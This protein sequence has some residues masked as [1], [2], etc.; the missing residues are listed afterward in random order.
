[1]SAITG[2]YHTNNEPVSIDQGLKMMKALQ[3]YPSDDVQI[4]QQKNVFLGCHAQWITPESIGEQLPYY[5]Y[6]RQLAITADAM[7]DNREELFDKLGIHHEE[8]KGMPDSQLI[9]LAYSKWED[10]TVKHLIGDFAFMIWDEK[11]QKLFGARDF[12][13]A[14][15]LYFYHNHQRFAFCTVMEPLLR[16]PY[17]KKE[18]NEEWL[19]EYLAIP[20][21]IDA[22]DVSKTVIKDIQQ[23]PPSHTINVMNCKVE[24]SKYQVLKSD[25][26]I[27][28]KTDVEYIETFRDIFQNA[29]DVRLRT[30]KEVGSH[31]SGGL[32]SGS[33]VS[34]AAKT[35]QKHNKKLH[36]YSSIPV[37]DFNDYT[38]KNY[39]PDERS[40]IRATVDYVGNIEDHYLSLDNKNPYTDIDDWLDI[41]ET[42]YKF[43]ENSF[44]MKGISEQAN[45]NNIGILL[46]GARGNFTISWGS[47][48][49]YYGHLLKRMKW[50][51]LAREFKTYSRNI[52]MGRKSLLPLIGKAAFPIMNHE[53]EDSF[54]MLINPNFAKKTNAF[55]KL[56]SCKIGGDGFTELS[57]SN[58]RNYLIDN[59]FIWNSNGVAFSKLSLQYGLLMRDP[60]NDIRVINYC[61]SLPLEQFINNGMDRA[62]IRNATKGYLPD[63][64]RLNQ[65]KY[66]LQAADWLH[67]MIPCW[68]DFIQEVK[69][70]LQDKAAAQYINMESIRNAL[71]TAMEMP[72]GDS[73]FNPKLRMLMRGIIVYRFLQSFDLEGGDTY[74]KRME[75]AEIGV[76]GC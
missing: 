23:V 18:L 5:D 64:V 3:K 63:K 75:R 32:D 11:K 17:I 27:K 43:F 30:F 35:L 44:W 71:S 1:M 28:F 19:A 54:P 4:W 9:L 25:E 50:I 14:R 2:I 10:E 76:V 29:N 74:E 38:P 51:S 62:L 12:S 45:K 24:L 16:L 40:Y 47:A 8:R 59:E 67:R 57:I 6:E 66:G 22:V 53:D 69:E 13:G 31:L 34:F 42:P 41:I 72:S 21:F 36:T 73:A 58:Q 46:N 68:T 37:T 70:L 48:I 61:M 7:I 52:G 15:P 39:I 49:E 55:E 20:T 56:E 26:K 65:S 60:T 33:V